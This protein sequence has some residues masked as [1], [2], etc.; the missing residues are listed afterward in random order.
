VLRLV[1]V[2]DPKIAN[3]SNATIT[4]PTT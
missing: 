3:A 1:L 2:S 4:I